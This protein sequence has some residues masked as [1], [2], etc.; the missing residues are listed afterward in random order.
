MLIFTLSLRKVEC[1]ITP[2]QISTC[3]PDCVMNEASQIFF[4]CESNCSFEWN[5][6]FLWLRLTKSSTHYENTPDSN[7]HLS[8]DSI[9][10]HNLF[11]FTV[12]LHPVFLSPL[13]CSVVILHSLLSWLVTRPLLCHFTE[14]IKPSVQTPRNSRGLWFTVCSLLQKNAVLGHWE[15]L[16]RRRR[17]QEG[18]RVIDFCWSREGSAS[19]RS[20]SDALPSDTKERAARPLWESLNSWKALIISFLLSR[21]QITVCYVKAAPAGTNHSGSYHKLCSSTK[22]LK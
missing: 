21:D 10:S 14:S 15:L 4:I 18:L 1:A 9:L 3:D 7:K 8:V 20:H 11:L 16:N 13:V 17:T 5:Y 19:D 22:P 12:T 2:P 6:C